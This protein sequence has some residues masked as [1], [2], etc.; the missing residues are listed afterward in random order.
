MT[1]EDQQRAD[2]QRPGQVVRSP[3]SMKS[4][5]LEDRGVDLEARESRAGAASSASSTPRVNVERVGPR[6]LLHHEHQPG[7]V[8]DDRVADQRLTSFLHVG[9]VTEA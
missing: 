3:S 1:S 6:E 8:V 4:A 5:G 7:P 9:D 2:D